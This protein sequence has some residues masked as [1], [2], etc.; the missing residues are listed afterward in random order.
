MHHARYALLRPLRPLVRFYLNQQTDMHMES[1]FRCSLFLEHHEAK[2]HW[3]KAEAFR[4][5][6]EALSSNQ[7]IGEPPNWPSVVRV[8]IEETPDASD[9][10]L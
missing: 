1:S 2:G 8:V 9:P 7:I 4:M 10:N 3:D 5:A 6:S